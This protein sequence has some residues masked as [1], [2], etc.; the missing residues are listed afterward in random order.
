MP[1][2]EEVFHTWWG[3]LF[4]ASWNPDPQIN[5]GEVSETV[6]KAYYGNLKIK[7]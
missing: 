6:H 4:T 7:P 5:K 2:R 3:L 1:G